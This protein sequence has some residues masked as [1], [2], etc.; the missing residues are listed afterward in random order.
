MSPVTSITRRKST[1]KYADRI[2]QLVAETPP[3]SDKQRGDIEN[4]LRIS[5]PA[6]TPKSLD[7]AA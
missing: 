2:R 1:Y 6:E 7:A 5:I 3:L 4:L